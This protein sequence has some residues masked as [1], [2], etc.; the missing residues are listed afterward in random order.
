[1]L[2]CGFIPGHCGAWKFSQLTPEI[3]EIVH[4]N[5]AYFN[6]ILPATQYLVTDQ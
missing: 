1:M 6:G 2:M 4:A 5:T 3:R